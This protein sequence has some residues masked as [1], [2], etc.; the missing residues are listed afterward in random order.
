MVEGYVGECVDSVFLVVVVDVDVY[1][2]FVDVG[3]GVGLGFVGYLFGY[4]CFCVFLGGWGV[5]W[6]HGLLVWLL[7]FDYFEF[8]ELFS[9][10]W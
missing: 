8:V 6:W 4:F 1:C 2:V 10:F 5:C 9:Y 7:W 3:F